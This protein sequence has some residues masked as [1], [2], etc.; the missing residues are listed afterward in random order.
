MHSC[1]KTSPGRC[2]RPALRT[3]EEAV[4]KIH[5]IN[6]DHLDANLESIFY[7]AIFYPLLELISALAI[8]LIIWYGGHQVLSGFLT[9]GNSGCI[10]PVFG[11]LFPPDFGPE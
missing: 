10:H 9:L 6:K 8:A 11:S 7:Y 2:C 5:P 1:R 4:S 3:T